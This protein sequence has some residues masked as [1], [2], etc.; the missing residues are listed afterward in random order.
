MAG[1]SQVAWT[2]VAK[3]LDDAAEELGTGHT[4]TPTDAYQKIHA[5][6]NKKQPTGVGTEDA[7]FEQMTT[8]QKTHANIEAEAGARSSSTAAAERSAYASSAP[9]PPLTKVN[10]VRGPLSKHKGLEEGSSAKRGRGVVDAMLA[11]ISGAAAASA[12][13]SSP[14][15]SSSAALS[16]SIKQDLVVAKDAKAGWLTGDPLEMDTAVRLAALL[17]PRT[18]NL[19]PPD[20]Q[21]AVRKEIAEAEE[22]AAAEQEPPAKRPGRPRKIIVDEYD[23]E[24][25]EDD[26][27]DEVEAAAGRGEEERGGSGADDDEE[28]EEEVGSPPAKV[29]KA[30]KAASAISAKDRVDI[31]KGDGFGMRTK[32]RKRGAGNRK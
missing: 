6:L 21:A 32:P 8:V 29:A 4:Y 17:P 5:I 27:E 31:T 7:E 2:R 16:G 23:K 20:L 26:V 30:A 19:L 12:S 10:A 18:L 13:A 25:A 15:V 9:P 14:G 22:A 1:A 28:E 24:E 11:A 3:A